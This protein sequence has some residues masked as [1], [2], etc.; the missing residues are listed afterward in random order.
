MPNREFM[1]ELRR[2]FEQM[3]REYSREPELTGHSILNHRIVDNRIEVEVL[4]NNNNRYLVK[5]GAQISCT[6]RG[7]RHWG[8]CKHVLFVINKILSGQLEIPESFHQ[9]L[10]SIRDY[11]CPYSHR[12]SSLS[13]LGEAYGLEIEVVFR[14]E[15]G[16]NIV[17][18]EL[19]QLF[20]LG[21]IAE[22]DGSLP[23]S[24]GVELKTGI[25]SPPLTLKITNHPYWK[26]VAEC[27]WWDSSWEKQGNH[28]HIAA[29]C[30]F[31][32]GKRAA[33]STMKFLHEVAKKIEDKIT[34]E[35][36]FGRRPNEYCRLARNCQ[37]DERYMWINFRPLRRGEGK[38]IEIRGFKTNPLKLTENLFRAK[39]IA[40]LFFRSLLAWREGRPD[41]ERWVRNTK[42]L[43]LLPRE[44]RFPT[45]VALGFKDFPANK[46]E[47]LVKSIITPLMAYMEA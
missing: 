24:R 32:I 3:M 30:F 19:K 41:P 46:D 8:R 20:E 36:V 31:A 18:N 6:C 35:K 39:Y 23:Y 37:P 34:F 7:F 40:N 25:L 5:I 11:L 9:A 22:E 45:L 28:V 26:R 38:T 1:E 13:L 21:L 27:E 2:K 15:I 4:S 47:F 42:L 12:T 29:D 44:E 17:N 14:P 10:E 16:L 43:S 33:T